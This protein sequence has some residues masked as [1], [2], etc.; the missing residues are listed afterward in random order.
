[1]CT[2][3]F[4]TAA[5]GPAGGCRQCRAADCYRESLALVGEIGRATMPPEPIAGLARLALTRAAIAKAA[6]LIAEVIAHFDAGGTIDGTEE[7]L[8]IVL[9]CH[10]VLAA[11]ASPRASEFLARAHDLLM[12]RAEPLAPAERASFLEQVPSHRAIAE[13]WAAA[14]WAG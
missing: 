10:Q 13:A 5:T 4:G 6:E 14:A 12:R 7:P 1:M 9:T 11:S 8:W 3:W 2:L